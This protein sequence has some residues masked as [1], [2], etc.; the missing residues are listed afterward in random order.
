MKT[1][2]VVKRLGKKKIYKK[3]I[4][5]K[6]TTGEKCIDKYYKSNSEGH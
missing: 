3:L 4:F 2:N 6:Y 5:S 1:K